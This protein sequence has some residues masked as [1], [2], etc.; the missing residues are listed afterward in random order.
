MNRSC[1]R[2]LLVAVALAPLRASA[3]GIS[4][5]EVGTSDVGLASAGYGARAQDASTV[6]TNP[7]GMTRLDGARLL[8]GGQLLYADTSF[9][10]GSGTSTGLGTNP[11]GNPVGWFP[12]GGAFF[13]WAISPTLA[14]GFATAGTFGLKLGYDPAWVGRYYAQEPTLIGLS[15]LPSIAWKPADQ[16]SVGASLHT[17]YGV[18]G[19][20]IAI[21][22]RGSADGQLS[23]DDTAWGVGANLGVL[24]EPRAGTRVGFVYNSQVKLNF[25]ATPEVKG[26][27]GAIGTLNIGMHVPQGV[28]V[29]ALQELSG[30]W[31]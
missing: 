30:S 19:Q 1:V 4:L 14:V 9:T 13:T 7:A 10:P 12:G 20:K 29:S 26:G 23:F 5:Y 3:G 25:S 21:N 18:L 11:G 24:W 6:L 15:M 28:M 17:M 27:S 22:E 8:V 16:L 31:A 2:V